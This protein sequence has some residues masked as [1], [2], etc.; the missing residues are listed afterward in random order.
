[1]RIL[2]IL[3]LII[4]QVVFAK[5]VLDIQNWATKN[6]TKVLFTE[7]HEL[8][9]V[10]I[11]V[12]FDAGSARDGKDFGLAAFTGAML[13]SGTKTLT[14]D[15]V[16]DKF[17]QIGAQFS[18]GTGYDTTSV[19]LRCLT[20]GKILANALPTFIDVLT[21]PAFSQ[22]EFDRVQKQILVGIQE[23][24]QYPASIASDEFVKQL[25]GNFPYGH[26]SL[27]T[28]ATVTALKPADLIKFH[29]TYYVAKN[30]IIVIVGD[31]VRKQAEDIVSKI[32]SKL[33]EGAKAATLP[34]MVKNSGSKT[35]HIDF[36]AMQSSVLIGQIGIARNDKDYLP[37]YVGN[38][39]L[40]QAP[41][42]SEFCREIREKRGLVYY[43]SSIFSASVRPG[44]F[45][46][47][48]SSSNEKVKEAI[49][50]TMQTL[51]HFVQ[52]GPTI[53]NLQ[54]AKNSLSARFP[55][56]FASNAAIKN[57][58]M[59]IGVYNLP[60]NYFDTYVNSLTTVT[61]EQVRDA[62]KRHINSDNMLTVTVG[63][64]LL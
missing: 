34:E 29:Q 60:L 19:S 4:S 42:I 40:G 9:M 39:M 63:K 35:F 37:L 47:N 44:P 58:L 18:V 15:Q 7:A 54:A 55:L 62:F 21:A 13:D 59:T 28:E 11:L 33:P 24:K 53:D 6:G 61:T 48:F 10:D 16:A 20:K 38:Y 8:P 57:K 50:V 5:P 2:L 46:I 49:T 27:G 12:V 3:V 26:S 14:A 41:L 17:E 32:T 25:Y 30:A 31:V 64:Q 23:Q 36:P 52:N 51:K 1:M 45:L 56:E 43:I 22:S